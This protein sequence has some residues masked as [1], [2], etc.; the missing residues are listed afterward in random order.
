MALGVPVVARANE[1]NASLITHG[2]T[3]LLFGTPAEAVACCV[4]VL[5]HAPRRDA[6]V[7]GA[8]AACAASHGEHA[9]AAAWRGVLRDLGLPLRPHAAAAGE[10]GLGLRRSL[11]SACRLALRP[12]TPTLASPSVL[13]DTRR[14]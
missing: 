4:D 9:E 14:E 11:A 12:R 2:A 10:R 5:E 1:G 3:G 6:L 7:A 13:K 8:R